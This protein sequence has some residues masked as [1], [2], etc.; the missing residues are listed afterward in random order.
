MIAE[1]ELESVAFDFHMEA[2]YLVHKMGGEIREINISY[3]FSNSSFNRNVLKQAIRF[4]W[5][6]LKK[7]FV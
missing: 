5:G 2:L 7:K 6:L 4:A 3:V 1:R